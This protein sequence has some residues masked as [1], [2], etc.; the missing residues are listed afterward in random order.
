MK[1]RSRRGRPFTFE[2][3]AYLIN[4][5]LFLV[6]DQLVV[7]LLFIPASSVSDRVLS[8]QTR[9]SIAGASNIAT[10]RKHDITP[11]VNLHNR[12]R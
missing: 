3:L 4:L 6:S 10:D 1:I 2:M 12:T 9:S 8:R 7:A 11:I 5:T